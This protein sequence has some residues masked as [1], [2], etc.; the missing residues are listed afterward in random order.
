M[1]GRKLPY[2]FIC[3]IKSFF[4]SK[5]IEEWKIRVS[6]LLI[7]KHTLNLRTRMIDTQTKKNEKENDLP[8]VSM[9][10]GRILGIV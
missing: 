7:F 2:N 8:D 4:I 6:R 5:D 1:A 9:I 3:Q 10:W